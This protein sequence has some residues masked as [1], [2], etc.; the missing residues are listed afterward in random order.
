MQATEPANVSLWRELNGSLRIPREC[1]ATHNGAVLRMHWCLQAN[2]AATIHVVAVPRNGAV[3]LRSCFRVVPPDPVFHE[4]SP[5]RF[6]P[7]QRR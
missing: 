6:T 3:L 4:R 2:V 1:Q 5:F 7:R